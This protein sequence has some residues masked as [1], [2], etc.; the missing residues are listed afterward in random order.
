MAQALSP[1]EDPANYSNEGRTRGKPSI[2]SSGNSG[3]PS[4]AATD[5]VA[6][7]RK[8]SEDRIKAIREGLSVERDL[9][10]FNE[11]AL[12]VTYEDGLISLRAFYDQREALRIQDLAKQRD[13]IDAEIAELERQ[14][15]AAVR[16]NRPQDV[17]DAQGKIA[18]ARA[19]GAAAQRESDQAALTATRDQAREVSELADRYAELDA[20]IAAL[21]GNSGPQELLDIS[22]QVSEAR[23]LLT[24]RGADPAAADELQA[25]L[26]RRRQ[27]EQI[28]ADSS[29]RGRA[30][31]N[32]EERV[33]IEAQQA[34][35]GLLD[36]ERAIRDGRKRSL[37]Q[38]DALIDRTRALADAG[39]AGAAAQLDDLQTERARLA[40][41]VDPTKLRFDAAAE[42]GAA[43]IADAFRQAGIEGRNLEDV[44][45]DLDKRLANLVL[46]EAIFKPLEAG[47]GSFFKAGN[48]QGGGGG[49]N[50]LD[51]ALNLIGSFF[52][53]GGVVGAL[54]GM[55]RAV[56]VGAFAGAYRYHSGG[57]AGLAAD[58]V[59]AVLRRGEEVLTEADP[60]HRSNG[61]GEQ[62]QSINI[63]QKFIVNGPVDRRSQA[64]IATAAGLG[65]QNALARNT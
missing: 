41:Q 23:R 44:V 56:P 45:S 11:Q 25:A 33:L 26:E 22:R 38:L 48:A 12:R 60:R 9:Y 52:H 10:Q 20:Q 24:Q 29:G 51:T 30:A 17:A 14:R 59:P 50:F 57:I 35:L 2:D 19:R 34:G 64:Q 61:G 53:G 31:A 3:N 32:A 63:S 15:D 46:D 55:Q 28:G 4:R 43:S 47:I 36:T 49:G 13:A 62:R 40:E 21:S 27:L 16:A 18:E 7:A 1:Y 58:E 8:F 42:E 6:A 65:I 39:T 54:G 37:D 5:A